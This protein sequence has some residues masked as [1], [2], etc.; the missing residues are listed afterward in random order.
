MK[1]PRFDLKRRLVSIV[2]GGRDAKKHMSPRTEVRGYYLWVL[3][4]T[5]QHYRIEKSDQSREDRFFS[6]AIIPSLRDQSTEFTERF[7]PPIRI[8][9]ASTTIPAS[10]RDGVSFRPR[11]SYALFRAG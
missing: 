3:A 9:G 8:S 4:G 2:P 11:E 1:V 5:F 10:P 7:G 6:N